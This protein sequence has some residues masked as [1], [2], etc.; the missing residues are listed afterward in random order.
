MISG[1]HTLQHPNRQQ[2]QHAM[3]QPHI[4]PHHHQ[5][6]RPIGMGTHTLGRLPS[7]NHSPQHM[8]GGG[9][10][11]VN[12]GGLGQATLPK[13]VKNGNRH[14]VGPNNGKYATLSKQCK[15]LQDN[16]FY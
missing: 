8:H 9:G 6:M 1:S 12:T 4:H 3:M 5:G 14:F 2:K 10:G 15:T 7:H 16:D 11:G 13:N